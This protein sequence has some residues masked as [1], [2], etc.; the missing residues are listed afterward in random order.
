MVN[1]ELDDRKTM[2][3]RL[4]VAE[5]FYRPGAKIPA[6]ARA[7]EGGFVAD[8]PSFWTKVK[9]GDRLWVR[10]EWRVS[11]KWDSTKPADLPPRA[12]SVLFT[13][14][15]SIANTAAGWAPDLSYPPAGVTV[16][17]A[18]RRRASMH[19]PRWAS[20]L[21]LIVT[22]VKIEPLQD[23]SDEDIVAEGAKEAFSQE[24]A[25]IPG[26]AA[27]MAWQEK[28]FYAWRD[29]WVSINGQDSWNDNPEV[30]AISFEVIKANIDAIARAA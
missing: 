11:K 30:V 7:V 18:G 19:M 23:I 24:T 22:A 28:A 2:T 5:R 12:M 6:D 25:A 20:R 3:R 26:P 13:A 10:E 4:A 21:T 17:W 8:R 29:L 1:A 16:P 15:G 27:Y 9:P 14:G